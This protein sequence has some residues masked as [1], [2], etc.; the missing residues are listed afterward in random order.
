[1]II[2]RKGRIALL[3]AVLLL[4][5]AA[6]ILHIGDQSMWL[7]E[8]IAYWNQ[9]QPSLIH[10]LATKDVHP[11][12]HFAA[13]RLWVELTG[14]TPVAMRM[15][16]A[17]PSLLSVALVAALA[18][19]LSR[20]RSGQERTLIPLIAA[21]LLAL[22]D[23]EIS[24]AQDVRMY[25]LRTLETLLAV[26]CYVQFTRRPRAV[27]GAGLVV[28]LAA[29]LHTH[30]IGAFM[31]PVLGLHALIFQRGRARA[32]VIA[33]MAL[34]VGLFMPWFAVY[35]WNQR[36]NDTGIMA[37]LPN[38]WQTFVEIGHKYFSQMW[39]VMFG[40][41]LLGVVALE[42][43][44]ERIRIRWQPFA[45]SALLLLWFSLPVAL[46]VAANFF[47]D[48][49]SPRRIL[50]I[51]PAIAIL[52][53]RGLGNLR[54]PARGFLI[55]AIVVYSLATVDDYYPKA[56][57]NAVGAN[58]AR[59]A[60]ADELVLMEIYRDDFTFDYYVD[61]LLSPQTP[62]ESLRR[63][64]EDRAY[65]YPQAL[66]AQMQ[67]APTIWLTHWSPDDSAFRFLEQTGHVQTALMTV[68]HWGNDLN[69][70]RFDRLPDEAV[71]E[72]ANGMTLR[73]VEIV[74]TRVDLWW[75]A[76]APLA[77]DYTTSVFLFN[78]AGVLA[79]QH[80][81]FPFENGRPTTTWAIGEVIYDPHPLDLDELSPGVYSVNVQ[82][83]TYFDGQKQPTLDGD[84][85]LAV[86]TLVR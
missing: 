77:L 35:G 33:L 1:M 72:F 15:S 45:S 56:P 11:P 64:R 31:L 16:S 43:E 27:W 57:W 24:L 81:A 74:D 66:I 59:Y 82:V 28:A 52:T 65:E 54:H 48:F 47:Y 55:G 37:A 76:A 84:L 41:L 73:H 68:D 8:G 80:D 20:S 29:L 10:E 7:D 62:R 3:T 51:S 44:G 13:L 58:L 23:P 22:F 69:L 50:L 6:R 53:A 25:A 19:T 60:A 79:A 5:A 46:T 32:L 70:Y 14:I 34:S 49:L 38:T 86:G 36:L 17:L 21:L 30:Y 9:K 83:Y 40:L 63:W 78:E 71:A 12:L 85:W 26:Y 61:Y 39:P 4:A 2:T 75:S 18:H 67:A 42:Y